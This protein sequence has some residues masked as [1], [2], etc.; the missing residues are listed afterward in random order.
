[1]LNAFNDITEKTFIMSY[2]SRSHVRLPVR[3]HIHLTF[4]HQFLV[5]EMKSTIFFKLIQKNF[6]GHCC[7]KDEGYRNGITVRKQGK[8]AL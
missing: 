8:W 5:Y 1:M 6:A 3:P 2:G 7:H 4:C